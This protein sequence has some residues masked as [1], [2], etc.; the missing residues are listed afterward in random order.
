VDGSLFAREERGT[1]PMSE[2]L[3]PGSPVR[4]LDDG[5]LTATHA[6]LWTETEWQPGRVSVVAGLRADRLP[7]NQP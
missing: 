4:G 1:V 2:A 5:T 3:S 7:G 6:G